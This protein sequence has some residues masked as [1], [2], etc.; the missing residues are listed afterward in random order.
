MESH[1]EERVAYRQLQWGNGILRTNLAAQTRQSATNAAFFFTI[2]GPVMIWQFGELA[3]DVSIDY[4]DRTGRK[5]IKWEYLDVPERRQLHDTYTQL[6]A[7]RRNHPELFAPT[8]TLSWQVT[9]NF[10]NNGRFLTLSS[11]GNEKQVVV[12]G[13]FT[14]VP[15]SAN[16]TFPTTG[17]WYNYM[18][19]PE[20]INVTSPTMSI[21]VPANDFRMFSTFK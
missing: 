9:S 18:N 6:I 20:I 2:P 19:Q 15:I 8:A 12:A 1:D 17:M 14:N 4:N 7:L 16:I 21:S 5:P 13:N 11:F 10:W 3:Y